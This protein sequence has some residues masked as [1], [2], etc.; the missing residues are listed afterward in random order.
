MGSDCQCIQGFCSGGI[1]KKKKKN[2]LKLIGMK[3]KLIGMMVAQLGEYIEKTLN[4][5]LKKNKLREL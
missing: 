5:R 4:C 1:I 3:K 2:A